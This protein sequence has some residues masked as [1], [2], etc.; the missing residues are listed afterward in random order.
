MKECYRK[1]V[2]PSRR[3]FSRVKD[4]FP[5]QVSSK[6]RELESFQPEF[7]LPFSSQ[8][9]IDRAYAEAFNLFRTRQTCNT[10]AFTLHT[11]VQEAPQH[12]SPLRGKTSNPVRP[13]RSRVSVFH[14]VHIGHMV[15]EQ[16]DNILV[17]N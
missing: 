1:N 16:I 4:L 14:T 9:Y 2:S 15:I 7:R 11:R 6:Q 5:T 13:H 8:M 10:R 17:L 3:T 12:P